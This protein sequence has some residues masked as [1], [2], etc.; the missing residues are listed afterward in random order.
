MASSGLFLYVVALLILAT[1]FVGFV[2]T[3]FNGV[4]AVVE[5]ALC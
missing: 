2:V 1:V 3:A 5:C 4:V